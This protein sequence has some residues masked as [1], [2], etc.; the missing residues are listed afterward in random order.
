[1]KRAKGNHG[2]FVGLNFKFSL[3][4]YANERQEWADQLSSLSFCFYLT[5]LVDG[6][7]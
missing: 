5:E 4:L 7:S 6:Y 1:M 2:I 3:Y